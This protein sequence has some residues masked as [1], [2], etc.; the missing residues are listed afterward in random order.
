[1]LADS[2][3]ALV[4]DASALCAYVY[5]NF[6]IQ[7]LLEHGE[8]EH[9]KRIIQALNRDLKTVALDQFGGN[10]LDKALSYGPVDEQR[11]IADL[12]LCEKG[13][14]GDMALLR[15][16]FAAAQRLIRVAR[17]DAKLLAKARS[18]LAARAC[19]IQETK[20]GRRF[21]LPRLFPTCRRPTHRVQTAASRRFASR[22]AMERCV[23]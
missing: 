13:L 11:R 3:G 4:C 6:V 21:F 14:L 17:A 9:R 15:S 12:V 16:G 7:H 19:E 5:G 18:Q 23:G 2:V 10:V 20:H 22:D 8:Q 1:M